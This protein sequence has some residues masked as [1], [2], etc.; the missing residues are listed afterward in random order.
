MLI[1]AVD[2]SNIV[3]VSILSIEFFLVFFDGNVTRIANAGSCDF[4]ELGVFS[5]QVALIN[6]IISISCSN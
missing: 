1:F 6:Y 4:R 3:E 2:N 5:S